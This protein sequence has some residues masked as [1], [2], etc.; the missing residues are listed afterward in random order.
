LLC[1]GRTVLVPGR[2][3]EA[4]DVEN[5]VA[6]GID[7]PDD[8]VDAVLVDDDPEKLSGFE[9]DRIGV[10]LPG[11]DLAF[12]GESVAKSLRR[13]RGRRSGSRAPREQE[14]GNRGQT[15]PGGE[16]VP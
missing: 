1:Y 3:G 16:R 2:P 15:P 9:D 10:T 13:G 14:D 11:P 6:L 5:R 8:H 12:Q 7:E 4:V